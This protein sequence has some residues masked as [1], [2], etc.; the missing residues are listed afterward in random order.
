MAF[1][2]VT[3]IVC[4]L[5][6]ATSALQCWDCQFTGDQNKTCLQHPPPDMGKDGVVVPE[7]VSKADYKH[8][9]RGYDIKTC[10]EGSACAKMTMKMHMFGRTIDVVSRQCMADLG[11]LNGR[12]LD[13][14]IPELNGKTIKAEMCICNSDNCNA[15]NLPAIASFVPILLS[16][17]SISIVKLF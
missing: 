12:C 1:I 3:L 13:Q 16:V 2:Q 17:F 15:A 10:D 6:H 5:L 11:S 14:E 7:G 8:L 4:A 9:F